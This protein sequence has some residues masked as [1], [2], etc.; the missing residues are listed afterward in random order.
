MVAIRSKPATAGHP[1][2]CFS[3]FDPHCGSAAKIC[4]SNQFYSFF[5][6]CYQL[7]LYTLR[8][9]TREREDESNSKMED[10]KESQEESNLPQDSLNYSEI[11]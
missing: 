10:S 11:T 3:H 5:K 1:G 8:N 7:S 9:Q 6:L 2:G 4:F